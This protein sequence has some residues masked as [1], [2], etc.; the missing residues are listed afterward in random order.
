MLTEDAAAATAAAYADQGLPGLADHAWRGS[1]FHGGWLMYPTGDDLKGRM[2]YVCLVVLDDGG[3]IEESSSMP[4]TWLMAMYMLDD[5]SNALGESAA[6]ELASRHAM[7]QGSGR[8]AD[9]WVATRCPGAWMVVPRDE[10]ADGRGGAYLV[11]LDNAD[12][13]EA[14]GRMSR[15]LT[16]AQHV[17]DMVAGRSGG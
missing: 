10:D 13:V 4:P 12:V 1:R 15:Q 9:G 14:S 11:V 17:A 8:P 7:A 6:L 2:G 16:V 5:A 3:I